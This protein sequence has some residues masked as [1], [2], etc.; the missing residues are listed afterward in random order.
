MK[1]FTLNVNK[2]ELGILHLAVDELYH[3]EQ[4][5]EHSKGYWQAFD[6]LRY[7]VAKAWAETQ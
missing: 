7:K 1:E 4:A 6:E 2:N 5:E 3:M